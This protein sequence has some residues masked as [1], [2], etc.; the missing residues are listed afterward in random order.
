MLFLEEK[1]GMVVFACQACKDVN[2]VQSVQV[3]TL[4]ALRAQV[5]EDLRR[6]GRLLTAPPKVR[7]KLTMDEALMI[8]KGRK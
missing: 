6:Q 5:R 2:K 3:I 7:R 1:A 8:A 4:P